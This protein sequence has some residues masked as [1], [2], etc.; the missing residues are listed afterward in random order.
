MSFQL[1]PGSN[2]YLSGFCLVVLQMLDCTLVFNADSEWNQPW[3]L[4]Q[5]KTNNN[6]TLSYLT[7]LEGPEL[8]I[9]PFPNFLILTFSRERLA[10]FEHYW[11]S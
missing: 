2:L 4:K 10:R 8:F 5:N 1:S 6:K 11:I 7:N 9:L 3:N